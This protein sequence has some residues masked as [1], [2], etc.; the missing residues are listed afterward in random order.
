MNVFMSGLNLVLVTIGRIP[1]DDVAALQTEPEGGWTGEGVAWWQSFAGLGPWLLLA[2]VLVVLVRAFLRR[3]RY[4]AV[5]VLDDAAMDRVHEA[6]RQAELHTVGEVVPV[7]VERSDP[8]PGAAWVAAFWGLLVGSTLLVG[9]L[10]WNQPMLLLACQLGLGAL[11]FGVARAL[12]DV[13]RLFISERR[14]TEVCEEQAMVEFHRLGLR[15]TEAATGVLVFVSLFEHRVVVL[16]DTGIDAVLDE[17]HWVA[18]TEAALAGIVAGDL[19]RGLSD[20]V[21]ACGAAL[22]GHF[23]WADG[24]RNELPDRL[25]VRRQ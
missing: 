23:P 21:E 2:V 14:A 15:D 18:V 8:H 24:D 11:G 13:S 17:Q 20:A 9:V 1:A 3:D 16:G 6:I 5:D 19:G 22:S 4:R 7:V 10:P 12:P 25:I